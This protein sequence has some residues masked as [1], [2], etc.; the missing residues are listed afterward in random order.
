M[1]A[2]L[3]EIDAWL[4][5]PQPGAEQV[6]NGRTPYQ[7]VQDLR[8]EAEARA[9]GRQLSIYNTMREE[10]EADIAAQREVLEELLDAVEKMRKDLQRG[11]ADPEEI[12]SQAAHTIQELRVLSEETQ[13]IETAGAMAT[14]MIDR[15]PEEWEAQQNN[16][17]PAGHGGPIVTVEFLRGE[18]PSPF[19]GLGGE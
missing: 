7:R 1:R 13:A 6:V 4:E 12:M 16:R 18:A 17:F 14:E 3:R 9:R 19:D 8:K 11:K 2:N 15:S 10:H 5:N